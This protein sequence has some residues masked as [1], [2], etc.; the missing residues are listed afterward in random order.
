MHFGEEMH[1]GTLGMSR[2]TRQ[3]EKQFLKNGNVQKENV[4]QQI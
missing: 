1:L 2:Q 4:S 3:L